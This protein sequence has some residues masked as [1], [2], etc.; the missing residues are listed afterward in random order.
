VQLLERWDSAYRENRRPGWDTGRPSSDLHQAVESG[1]LK[2][3]RAVE[4]G[5]GTGTN[6]IYLAQQGFDVTA[7]DLAPTA[8][9]WAEEKARAEG[10]RVRWVLAD[11]LA[12]PPLEPFDLVYDRGCYHG[13]RRQ[14]AEA[15]LRAVRR[16]TN[17]GSQVLI[18]AGNA[19][20]ERQSG[21]PRVKEE[22]LRADF[23]SGFE[24]QWLKTTRFDTGDP[25]AQGALAWSVLL[26]RK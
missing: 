15:Y 16:L 24:F 18:Q 11:V 17:P 4:F 8:L 23:S 9:A 2:R 3:C 21:P 12:P 19:N 22:E 13:V 10:V 5:C 20:E 26:R 6:A 25:N 1:T 7:I 14:S